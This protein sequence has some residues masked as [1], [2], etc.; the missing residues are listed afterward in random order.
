MPM[1]V[2]T[3][4]IWGP[5]DT[6]SVTVEPRGAWLPPGGSV[7]AT[8]PCGTTGSVRDD[9]STTNP[10][11]SSTAV[12]ASGVSVDVIGTA[13][14]EPGPAPKYHPVPA[15]RPVSSNTSAKSQYP[16]RRR[17]AALVERAAVSSTDVSWVG[18]GDERG[19]AQHVRLG[20]RAGGHGR[21]VGEHHRGLRGEREVGRPDSRLD[22]AQAVEQLPRVAGPF[23][24]VARRRPGDELVDLG[25]YG[26]ILRTRSGHRVVGVLVGDLHRRFA[27]VRLLAG[28]HL[29]HH[30]ADRVYVAA[31]IGDAAGDEFGGEVGDGAEQRLP[32][33]RVRARRASESEVAELDSAVVGEQHVL[34]LH[35]AVHDARLVRGGEPRQHRVHDVDRLLGGEALVVLQQ[36]AQRDARQVLHDQV[37]HVGV[38]TLVEHVHDVGMGQTRGRPGLLHESGLERVVVGEVAVHDLQRHPTLEPQVGREVHGGHAAASDPR[39]HLIATVDQTADHG[40]GGRGGHV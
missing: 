23:L 31:G 34:W 8:C 5:S 3:S 28:E 1:T 36:V 11:S 13:V 33:G 21:D 16:R 9:G 14:N 19:A 38:L 32:G 18:G 29:V 27:D 35:V 4:R 6:K 10:A 2:G 24:G 30:D 20:R 39:A 7:S 40:V 26:R 25:G 37:R 22:L 15:A 12:A 17:R